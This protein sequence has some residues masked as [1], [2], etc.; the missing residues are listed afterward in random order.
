[1][2]VA[3]LVAIFATVH[4]VC[5]T[6]QFHGALDPALHGER[7]IIAIAIFDSY[8]D[9]IQELTT[10]KKPERRTPVELLDT[11]LKHTMRAE[12]MFDDLLSSLA[13]LDGSTDWKRCIA[14]LRR[15]I[16]LQA[17]LVD[18]PWPAAVWIDLPSMMATHEGGLIQAINTFLIDNINS[19]T[20]DRY[21]ALRAKRT[22][23]IE[24][25]KAYERKAMKRWGEY[26]EI[27]NPYMTAQFNLDAYPKLDR[28]DHV[29]QVNDWINSSIQDQSIVNT[30][31]RQFA[32][33]KTVH[34]KQNNEVIALVQRARSELGFD[35]WSRGCGHPTNS[36][37]SSLKN[38]LLRRSA[39]IQEL[40]L[41]TVNAMLQQLSPE[42]LQQ[43][44]DR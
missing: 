29:F 11:R 43:F 27:I 40:Q 14:D 1:M 21:S 44:E 28:G 3:A 25:C 33:W 26:Q 42:Q 41:S 5:T 20:I 23:D 31:R 13:I 22:G 32:L 19:D 39:E 6:Q 24:S 37:A 7:E 16:L 34:N 36:I 9:Q 4:P 35:P 12:I 38:K 8:L 17:R 30:T 18:N 2:F 15:T 10:E